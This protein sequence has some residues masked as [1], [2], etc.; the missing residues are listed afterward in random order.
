MLPGVV[1]IGA[2]RVAVPRD[3]HRPIL[4]IQNPLGVVVSM[5]ACFSADLPQDEEFP[6]PISE[7][8]HGPIP[9]GGP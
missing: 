7:R 4:L 8:P 5:G 2:H 9:T 1:A 6:S 3:G